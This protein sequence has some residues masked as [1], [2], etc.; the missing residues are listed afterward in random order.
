MRGRHVFFDS[1]LAHGADAIFG[2]P[3][4]TENP[5]LDSLA[6]YPQVR[7]FVALH[8]GV[9]VCAAG[10]YAMASGKTAIANLHVAPGL[11]NAIGMMYG[12]MKACVPVI[13]T[14]GQQDTRM[15]LRDPILRHDLVAMAAP[16]S[17]WAVEAQTADEIGPIMQ[18]AFRIANEH[19]AGPVFVALPNNVMSSVTEISAT[20]AGTLFCRNPPQ[21]EAI[22]RLADLLLR[23]RNPV[24]F[25]G[26]AIAAEGA[27]SIFTQLVETLGATVYTEL[28]RSRQVIAA[29][30][31]SL[32]GRIPITAGELHP[33]LADHDV[34]LLIGGPFVE[35]IWFDPVS[36]I[37]ATT[38]VVQIDS[39]AGRLA[40][41]YPV[42]IGVLG[43]IPNVLTAL[44]TAVNTRSPSDYRTGADARNAAH[45]R[46]K[47][48]A[49]AK[50]DAAIK[51]ASS[52][53]PMSANVALATLADALPPQV[54]VVNEAV[55]A[56]SDL[57][58][59]FAPA[60]PTDFYMGR[61]GGIGQGVA[62]ALGIAVAHPERTVV[63]ISGDGS[64]MYSIQALWTAAHHKLNIV[65]VI[66]ANREYRV[67]K[68]NMDTHRHRFDENPEQPYPHMDLSA[69][70]L[71][72]VDL[73][74][75][76]GVAAGSAATPD[77]I[78]EQAAAAAGGGPYLLELVIAGKDAR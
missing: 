24:I 39:A 28:L 38:A 33:L 44:N 4:T 70:T 13:V 68:H 55:T 52:R 48:A 37:P 66:L 20:S 18:R 61:G 6:D 8:E 5:L 25:A 49:L 34:A 27:N 40:Y 71:R 76:M 67:L 51:N 11:G 65:F 1:L 72:F 23:A 35:E 75:G 77:E 56:A 12:A 26:D 64:A 43:A 7:Y 60:G 32:R 3:G 74:R 2:N 29:R 53:T 42:D 19:P 16:V 78:R 54:I 31:P 30:H 73:A 22:D 58:H 63:A 50:L 36:P 46:T 21:T 59:A 15:R 17:K 45:A 47:T 69:P 41:N 10:H 14:A 9:A 57:E 62:G